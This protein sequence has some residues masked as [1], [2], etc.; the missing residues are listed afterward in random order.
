MRKTEWK[1]DI[2]AALEQKNSVLGL[3]NLKLKLL[4][5]E[6]FSHHAD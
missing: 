2:Q 6:N 1:N 4:L 3:F 5:A